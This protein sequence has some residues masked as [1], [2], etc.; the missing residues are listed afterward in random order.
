MG[1]RDTYTHFRRKYFF[2]DRDFGH[3]NTIEAVYQLVPSLFLWHMKRV[4]KFKV[5]DIINHT[6]DVLSAPEEKSLLT[7]ISK[8]YNHPP[9]LF[10]DMIMESIMK[11]ARYE[12]EEFLS[13]ERQ[14]PLK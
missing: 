13:E 11:L 1:L 6:P 9:F 3:L 8:H 5:R 10:R 12:M 14:A 2:S 4:I 7:L